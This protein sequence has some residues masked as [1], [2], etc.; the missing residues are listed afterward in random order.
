M[1]L[2]EN[3]AGM[4]SHWDDQNLVS[5][6]DPQLKT[7]LIIGVS[8]G[9]PK[10]RA[11]TVTSQ[12]TARSLYGDD[13]TL[14]RGMYEALDAGAEQVRLYRIGGTP[15]ILTGIATALTFSTVECRTGIE[16]EFAWSWITDGV[17]EATIKCWY[18]NPDSGLT[19]LV[20]EW[21]TSSK[22]PTV[23]YGY[24][25]VSKNGMIDF[26]E[27]SFGTSTVGISMAELDDSVSGGLY[28]LTESDSGL[29][30]TKMEMYELLYAAYLELMN[31]YFDYVHVMG[32][33]LDDENITDI[34]T[35]DLAVWVAA[36]PTKSL[37]DMDD[38]ADLFEDEL[39][40]SDALAYL[41]VTEDTNGNPVFTWS[42]SKD[43]DY[44]EVNFA[45]QLANFCYQMSV[46]ERAVHGTIGVQPPS[47]FTSLSDLNNWVGKLPTWSTTQAGVITV[48]GSG[49]LGNK[50]MGGSIAYPNGLFYATEEE[51]LDGVSLPTDRNGNDIDIGRYISVYVDY[52][53]F[54]SRYASIAYD[55]KS[56]IESGACSYCGYLASLDARVAPTNKTIPG[57]GK[58]PY[59]LSLPKINNLIE[60]RYVVNRPFPSANREVH[61]IARGVTAAREASDYREFST[62]N[63]VKKVN[64]EIK[65]VAM[66]Y[67]GNAFGA[68]QQEALQTDLNTLGKSLR[69]NG[70]IKGQFFFT[71]V[72]T[73]LQAA[74]GQ[75]VIYSTFTPAFEL[76]RVTNYTAL[77][78]Q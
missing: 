54:V 33:A 35:S 6:Y 23:D 72:A 39:G 27:A 58:V 36:N 67:I 12:S 41:K 34:S 11:Y 16:S 44:H 31:E 75:L 52:H 18:V 57:P 53:Y 19:T 30:Q 60:A 9:G 37:S 26:T 40:T 8:N 47:S 59:R 21:T 70:Y 62:F 77:M 51:F 45:Y 78:L 13:G 28:P 63:I 5:Q 71:P 48:N 10:G 73:A 15:A 66:K 68:L 43:T 32:I 24:V 76:V 46:N 50:F 49:L 65:A 22:L 1:A 42:G 14:I 61:K 25:T 3:P 74:N 55:S 7:A 29:T 4:T 69:D 2:Y 17:D 56:Y 38:V 64:D 20:Y